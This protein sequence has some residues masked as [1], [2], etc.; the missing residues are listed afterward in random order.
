MFTRALPKQRVREVT[1][2]AHLLIQRAD[3]V[4]A[5]FFFAMQPRRP[6]PAHCPVV[7]LTLAA[8]ATA[9]AAADIQ[10]GI[11]VVQIRAK[12]KTLHAVDFILPGA[13]TTTT[14]SRKTV[15]A[16]QE[17]CCLRPFPRLGLC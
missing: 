7:D 6:Q 4:V 15:H 16:L 5:F 10:V 14:D 1:A 17:G 11:V 12:F 9:A 2:V 8:T 13:S 3:R